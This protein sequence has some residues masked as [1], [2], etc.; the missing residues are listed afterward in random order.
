MPWGWLASSSVSHQLSRGS[1]H[2]EHSSGFFRRRI[3]VLGNYICVISGYKALRKIP[4]S[5]GRP[6]VPLHH[7]EAVAIFP[8]FLLK[9][10]QPV[11]HELTI[12]SLKLN[13][14]PAWLLLEKHFVHLLRQRRKGPKRPW[15]SDSAEP[16]KLQETAPGNNCSCC[17]FGRSREQLHAHKATLSPPGQ[18]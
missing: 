17:T 16:T 6:V 3:W 10:L 5:R 15:H 4:W 8:S 11:S 9:L 2:S 14:R 7:V 1:F 12:R 18:L 13:C